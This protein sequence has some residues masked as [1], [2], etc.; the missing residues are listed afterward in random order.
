MHPPDER[1]VL[2]LETQ[3]ALGRRIVLRAIQAPDPALLGRLTE[4]PGYLLVEYRDRVG[5]YFWDLD[6]LR[7]VLRRAREGRRN[8]S[9]YE[10]GRIGEDNRT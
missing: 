5:G 2:R 6:A 9:I 4:R 3:D 7:E 10:E 8:V 1:D